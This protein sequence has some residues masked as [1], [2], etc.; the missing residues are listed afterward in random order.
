MWGLGSD[1]GVCG[2]GLGFWVLGFGVWGLGFGG[3]G[4]GFGDWW[5]GIRQRTRGF[6]FRVY[7]RQHIASARKT[8]LKQSAFTLGSATI[9]LIREM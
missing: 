4:L 7:Q 3:W 6:G 8:K 9:R 2:L 1:V 5:L